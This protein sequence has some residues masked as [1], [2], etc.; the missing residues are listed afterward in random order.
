MKF[1][2]LESGEKREKEIRWQTIEQSI[3]GI[4][5]KLGKGIDEKIKP[6]VVALRASG[7]STTGSCEGHSDRG[8]P[9]PWVDVESPLAEKL[10]NDHRYYELKEKAR[11]MNKR[12][13]TMTE[14]EQ[15][16]YSG[17]VEAQIE[18]NE[19]EYQRIVA[20]LDEFYKSQ[21]EE[22][23]KETV[24]LGIRK[25]PWNQSRVQPDGMPEW[26][27]SQE[28]QKLWSDKEK[29]EKL[30]LYR[31][32]MKRFSEFLKERFFSQKI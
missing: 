2:E 4:K 7:F 1:E 10:L 20:I 21:S 18:K 26:T 16:E 19:K 22:Q 13:L 12:T 27:K 24:R 6:I 3:E 11:A 29:L 23:L 14:A 31:Q 9:W 8:Y 30:E 28:I 15:K 5:D 32:E 17:L 25:G